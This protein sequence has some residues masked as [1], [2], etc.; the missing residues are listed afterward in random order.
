[1]VSEQHIIIKAGPIFHGLPKDFNH[2][3][4]PWI[5]C[6]ARGKFLR[7]F[8]SKSDLY[9]RIKMYV[10]ALRLQLGPHTLARE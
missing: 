8:I 9:K 2:M 5:H 6:K 10:H 7:K 4:L 1:M 3:G